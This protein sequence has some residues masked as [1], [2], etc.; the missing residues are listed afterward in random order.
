MKV[1]DAKIKSF[2]SK[3][4]MMKILVEEQLQK[5]MASTEVEDGLSDYG[6]VVTIVAYI[7][8]IAEKVAAKKSRLIEDEYLVITLAAS[9]RLARE[10]VEKMNS[11]TAK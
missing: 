9:S 11:Q 1:K 10:Y 7:I 5:D 4:E 8:E 3:V 2:D 6:R